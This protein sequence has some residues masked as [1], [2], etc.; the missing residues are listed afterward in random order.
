MLSF[1]IL[2]RV[3]D[4]ATQFDWI[5]WIISVKLFKTSHNGRKF[6]HDILVIWKVSS[7]QSHISIVNNTE[8]N[9][10]SNILCETSDN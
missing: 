7:I 3:R 9:Y 1:I 2:Y 5:K 10:I 6:I 8:Y 4:F